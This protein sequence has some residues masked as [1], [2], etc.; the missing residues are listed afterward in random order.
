MDLSFDKNVSLS[1]NG[2][3]T[4]YKTVFTINIRRRSSSFN[5]KKF[6]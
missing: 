3:Y 1:N 5:K 6:T 4:F 2:K